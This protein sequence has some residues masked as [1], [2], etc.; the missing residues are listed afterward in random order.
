MYKITASAAQVKS[1]IFISQIE[2]TKN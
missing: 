2:N 1:T